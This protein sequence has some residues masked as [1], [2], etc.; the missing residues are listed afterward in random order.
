MPAGSQIR[1]DRGAVR[2]PERHSVRLPNHRLAPAF[3][4]RW[5]KGFEEWLPGPVIDRAEL[6]VSEL[7]T[8]SVRHAGLGPDEQIE[9]RLEV[10]PGTLRVE[11]VDPGPGF[12]A[13]DRPRP[14]GQAGWGLYLVEEM[15]DRWGAGSSSGTV[16]W[17]ELDLARSA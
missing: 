17:F 2:R 11:V 9:L 15:T 1:R 7:I 16:V 13:E 8:N 14:E 3:G 4:R 10:K 6:L 12:L 5:V